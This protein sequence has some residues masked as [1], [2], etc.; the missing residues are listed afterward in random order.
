MVVVAGN[1]AAVHAVGW[2]L[3][4]HGREHPTDSEAAGAGRTTSPE[5]DHGLV[6]GGGGTLEQRS[7]ALSLGR[8]A[9]PTTAAAAR[10]PT[11]ARRLGCV[12]SQAGA[13]TQATKLWI[14][15]WQVTH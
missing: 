13:Q 8:Q 1:P 9:L 11:S 2:Q 7:D 6:G 15:T 12:Q 14:H 3:V 5:P 10:T 4:E